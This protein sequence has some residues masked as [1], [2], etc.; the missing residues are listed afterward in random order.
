MLKNI[1]NLG[2]PLSTLEKQ[3]INGGVVPG[4]EWHEQYCFEEDQP[5][6]CQ[7]SRTGGVGNTGGDHV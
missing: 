5:G 3:T 4:T 2:S 6:Y 1:S 7:G